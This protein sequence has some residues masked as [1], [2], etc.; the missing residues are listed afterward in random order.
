MHEWTLDPSGLPVGYRLR[1]S[2]EIWP[3]DARDL[4]AS[5]SCVLIDC[6]TP[7]EYACVRI[8]GA[9]LIPLAEIERRADEI[10]ADED[11]P[12]LVICHHGVRSQRAALALQ[13][14]GF[15]QARSI[16]GGIDLWAVAIDPSLARYERT[17]SGMRIVEGDQ[18][19]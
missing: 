2:F 4:L 14:L 17:G 19:S 3:Q 12:V 10:E 16:V 9:E 8:E 15:P 5:G 7:E 18:S 13:Q 6:R 1:P 11:T